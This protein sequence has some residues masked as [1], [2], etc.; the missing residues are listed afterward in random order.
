[1]ACAAATHGDIAQAMKSARRHQ[2]EQR[3]HAKLSACTVPHQVQALMV[4]Q[5]A[6]IQVAEIKVVTRVVT[7]VEIKAE[8]RAETKVETKAAKVAQTPVELVQH[9]EQITHPYPALIISYKHPQ[10]KDLL[11]L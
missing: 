6:Q 5:V 10:H 9:Q 11:H 2:S 3:K 4:V 1:M 8:T 7:R